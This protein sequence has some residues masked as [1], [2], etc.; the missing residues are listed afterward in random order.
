MG[1][2]PR[3][4]NLKAAPWKI[5]NLAALK[6]D[7]R[8]H[9]PDLQR[10]FV[11]SADRV[12]A[13]YD[14]LYR[15]YPVGAL[16]LWE[17]KWQGEAPFSTR[18]WDICP[19]DEL[20]SRGAPEPPRPVVPGSLFVLDGQQRLTSIFRLVFRS[21]IR[22]KTT[23]DPD[24][25]VALSPR[26][27]WVENPFH[28]RSKPLYR[29]MREGL[30]VPAEV[31]FEGIR[32]GNESLAVQR[33]LGE[34]LTTGDELFFEALDRA[35]A[36]RTS[37][38]QAEVI[39]Y[40]IDAD[41]ND[42]N[43]IEIFA[44]LNQQ[45][46][47]LRPGDLAA[48]RLTG[49]M[50]NFRTRAREV[51]LMK[52]LRGFSAPEGVEEGSRSGAFVDTDLLIRAALFLG[53]GGVR[54][55]DAEKRKVQANYQ[56]I[57]ANWDAAVAGFKSAVALF[58]NAGVPSGEW[59]P[60]RY[61]LFPPAIAVARGQALDER[62]TGWALAASLWR[63]YAGEVDTKLAKDA[64]LAERG[65][66]DGLIEHVKLRAK[67]PES[68][69]P[70]DDDVLHNIVSDSAVL[71]ALLAYFSRVNAHSFPSGKLLGGAQEPLEVHQI[72]PRTSIDRY[73]GRDNEYVPDRLGNLTLL[74]RSDSEHIGETAPD[75]YLNIVDAGDR[76]VHLIPE[77]PALWSIGRYQS[78]CEQRERALAAMLR[79]LL[80]SYRVA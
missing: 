75:V 74:A 35:N 15:S 12:R 50:A 79:D 1:A 63:H 67:R 43:V 21:R 5:A 3:T 55:R 27:E 7:G 40:E 11:W 69:V 45:G 70:D 54:Y 77:Q 39:A 38:L 71:F 34:W 10:G 24:L 57:E 36:I 61:L 23:P 28:L 49:Q 26:D 76:A 33:A 16:L 51:L 4:L 37:I 65:D 46:V 56:N 68:A 64:S 73:P 80:Y 30:L 13:L 8:L 53:G 66:I 42:D 14:S 59:L 44:R 18:G 29:R 48:A 17:P 20:T 78:F 58:R 72:F 60:Y 32:G 9:L 6:R 25:L 62:W 47:R 31:L 19:P 2:A 22:D 41:A 52:E